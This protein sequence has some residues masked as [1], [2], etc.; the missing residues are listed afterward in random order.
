MSLS[1]T[2]EHRCVTHFNG[3]ATIELYLRFAI[4]FPMIIPQHPS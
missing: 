1:A 2:I 4:L 3:I